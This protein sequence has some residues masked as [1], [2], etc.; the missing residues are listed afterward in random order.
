MRLIKYEVD[1]T[2]QAINTHLTHLTRNIK[3]GAF[4][5][6]HG[7]ISITSH[8]THRNNKQETSKESGPLNRG[9]SHHKSSL[10]KASRTQTTENK[11]DK[12]KP[13]SG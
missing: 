9:L 5:G 6:I 2:E 4:M 13:C 1:P 3:A 11:L 8:L 10:R 12:K 7:E